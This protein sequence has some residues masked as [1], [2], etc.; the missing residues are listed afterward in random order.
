M[1][2]AHSHTVNGGPVVLDIGGDIGALVV[3]TAAELLGTEIEVQ[4]IDGEE[5]PIHT[6]VH[7]RR[8]GGEEVY[9]GVFA[10]L[11]SGSHRFTSGPGAGTVVTIAG[12]SVTE[13]DWR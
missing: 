4:R 11:S 12:G 3:Y 5:D 9:A 7:R 13:L 1:A 10:Q 8:L 2:E 6:E